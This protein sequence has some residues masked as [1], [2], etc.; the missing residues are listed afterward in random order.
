VLKPAYNLPDIGPAPL[1]PDLRGTICKLEA[2]T[3]PFDGLL[4]PSPTVFKEAVSSPGG[5]DIPSDIIETERRW[6]RCSSTASL[7]RLF[8][9]P[10]LCVTRPLPTGTFNDKVDRWPRLDVAAREF[11]MLLFFTCGAGV[12]KGLVFRCLSPPVNPLRLPG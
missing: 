7:G 2:R 5:S 4:E 8:L 1:I 12:C 6:G 9:V 3:W 11:G 10:E